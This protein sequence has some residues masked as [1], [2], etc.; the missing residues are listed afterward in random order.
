MRGL[1][2]VFFIFLQTSSFS[3]ICNYCEIQY[4][5]DLLEKE[6]IKFE[7]KLES[8]GEITL[9]QSEKNFSKVWRFRYDKCLIL[10]VYTF[11]RKYFRT[12]KRALNCQ[13]LRL[14]KNTWDAPENK[15]ELDFTQKGPKFTFRPKILSSHNFTKN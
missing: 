6:N 11:R 3:Q 5:K 4:V 10:E 2:I 14:G 7:E 1:I 9:S 13:F 12:M 15:I 8:N